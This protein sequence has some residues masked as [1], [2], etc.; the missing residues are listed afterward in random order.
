MLKTIV[1]DY[2]DWH[3]GGDLNIQ[4]C[5]SGQTMIRYNGISKEYRIYN[6]TSPDNVR[7]GYV[8]IKHCP[9]CGTKLP[10]EKD[11]HIFDDTVKR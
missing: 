7:G 11:R 1:K 10:E 6:C 4:R 9:W 5:Q 2:Y 8:N 3:V